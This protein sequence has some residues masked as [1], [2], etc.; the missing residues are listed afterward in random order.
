MQLCGFSRQRYRHRR[1]LARNQGDK[2][3][4]GIASGKGSGAQRIRILT[5]VTNPQH[6]LSLAT[7]ESPTHDRRPH[8]L[9]A[10]TSTKRGI[11][12]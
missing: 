12:P 10:R 2:L 3:R 4:D 9:F 6:F 1:N 7:A 5:D 11:R 8:R